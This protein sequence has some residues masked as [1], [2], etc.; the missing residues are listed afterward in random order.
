MPHGVCID[1]NGVSANYPFPAYWLFSY[2]SNL[3]EAVTIPLGDH[4]TYT[5]TAAT[6]QLPTVFYPGTHLLAVQINSPLT[7]LSVTWKLND[8]AA[9]IP[10]AWTN[11]STCPQGNLQTKLSFTGSI[12]SF[13]TAESD[14]ATY[15]AAVV[16][17][18]SV[19]NVIVSITQTGKKRSS[20]LISSFDASITLVTDVIVGP[21]TSGTISAFGMLHK[22]EANISDPVSQASLCSAIS[23]GSSVAF[24]GSSATL[25]VAGYNA[26][27]SPVSTPAAPVSDTPPKAYSYFVLTS[28]QKVGVAFAVLFGVAI[29]VS[30]VLGLWYVSKTAGSGSGSS[31][32]TATNSQSKSTKDEK[33]GNTSK[34]SRNEADMEP[35]TDDED[36][37]DDEE[38]DDESGDD[39]EDSS[40][41]SSQEESSEQEESQEEDGED[42]EDDEEDE[43]ES[44]EDETES[45]D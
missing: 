41:E 16:G 43:E 4:N 9:T 3:T 33:S 21:P 39:D 8:Y 19:S 35:A 22:L 40:E 23:V 10:F 1:L 30:V 27:Y 34:D 6:A 29:I 24:A 44:E 14:L 36:D 38:D 42:E 2:T 7:L 31:V 17:A 28:P 25:P 45:S 32:V 26:V 15:I 37:D 5:P 11:A 12:S 13:A 20:S 18:P